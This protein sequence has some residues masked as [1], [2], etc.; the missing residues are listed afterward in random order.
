MPSTVPERNRLLAAL[1]RRERNRF[2]ACSRLVHLAPA[3]VL[4]VSGAHIR[5][6]Y[7]PLAGCIS[8]S[9]RGAGDAAL[10]I[11]LIG[12]EGML[13]IGLVLGVETSAQVAVVQGKGPALR[14]DA[15]L[16]RNE[17]LICPVLVRVLKRYVHVLMGQLAQ[18]ATCTRFHVVDARLARLLLM[19]QDR[20]LVQPLYLTHEA[21]AARLGVRRAGITA[22][23]SALQDHGLIAYHRGQVTILDRA[24]LKAAACNCYAADND[25]YVRVMGDRPGRASAQLASPRA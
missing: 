5:H 24:G 9:T 8:L 16:F 13:G 20:D 12:N 14:V 11:G 6:A 21:L 3:D 19:T 1:P 7:F 4:N 15:A 10:D 2:A 23:A 17:L 18:Y 25:A 22:A